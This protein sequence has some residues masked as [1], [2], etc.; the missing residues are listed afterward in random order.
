MIASRRK[1]SPTRPSSRPTSRRRR[2]RG[3][4]ACSRMRVT[5]SLGDPERRSKL[6]RAGDAA[7]RQP[8][9]T[10]RRAATE[11]DQHVRGALAGVA[12]PERDLL[13]RRVRSASSA[14][15]SAIRRGLG[16]EQR[17]RAELD[18]HRPLGRVAQREARHAERRRLLLHAARV[19]EHEARLRL[20]PEEVEVAERRRRC[21]RRRP[22]AARVEPL[23]R[24][25]RACA[26]APGRRPASSRASSA[27][28]VDRLARAARGRRRA[29]AGAASRARSAPGSTPKRRP[30]REL[31]ARASRMREAASR[32]SC[33]RRGGRVLASIPSR[34]RF[35]D[36]RSREWVSS[37]SADVVGEPAVV[38]LR[39]RRV[40]APQPGLEVRD[41]D[42]RASTAAS[43]AAS[44]ELTSPGTTTRSGSRS[45][46][47]LL[48]A[49]ERARRL[50]AVACPSRRRGRRPARAGR[51][52]SRKTSD[53]AGVVVLAGVD[54][55][56]LDAP[57]SSRASARDHRRDLHEV[58]ARAHDE[59]DAAGHRHQRI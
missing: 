48:D 34:S 20:E 56:D 24:A 25:A 10:A 45:T 19:G 8:T 41:R 12:V 31:R 33:C 13:R 47:T 14:G 51:A 5:Y 46:S 43:A 1:P 15:I 42:A 4:R 2:G 50:L 17:V 3:A 11:L 44:V 29:P 59:A 54:E 53:I 9:A 30:R 21:R 18:R 22:R 40:E 52:R 28:A 27:S 38:L 26:G 57:G 6:Q 36:A 58:R 23:A 55:Q 39:H 7:H 35:V 16:A 32:S 49:D 37:R